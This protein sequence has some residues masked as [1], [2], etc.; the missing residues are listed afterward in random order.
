MLKCKIDGREYNFEEG[1]TILS[2]CI[3]VGIDIP[4]LC[5]LDG[6]SEEAACSLCVV[7]VKG[8]RTLIRACVTKVVEGME[9]FTDTERVK[10]ARRLNLELILANHPLDCMTC[11]K[12]GDC[13]LQDLAYEFDI[14]KSKFL[15]PDKIVPK[16]QKTPWDT[17]PFIEFDPDKCVLCGRCIN[18][19]SNQAVLETI[20]FAN[21]GHRQKVCPPFSMP[22]EDTDCKF[23][24]VCVQA[25]PV[26]ALIEKPRIGL[27]KLKDLIPTDTI[28]AYCGVGCN[29]SIYKDKHDKLIMAKGIENRKI[30]NGRLCVKGR[31]GHEYIDSADRLT[32]PLIKENG[33]FREATWAEA[34]RY[35]AKKL[36]EIKSKYSSDSIGVLGSSRCTNE[37]NYAIQKFARAVIGTNNVDNCARLCHSSTVAG[38]GMAFGAGAAT[39]SIQ[40]IEDSDLIFIIGSNMAET[41]PVIAQIVKGHMKKNSP[42]LIVCDPRYVGMAKSADLYI[43]HYPGTDV[44]LLNAIMK[45]IIE[46]GNANEEFI[47]AHAEGFDEF[48]KI[49]EGYDVN[50]ASKITGVDQEKIRE[51]AGIIG[52]AKSMMIFFSMGITQHTTGVDNVLSVANLALLTGN[53]GRRGAGVMPLRGQ[54]NVQGACDLGALPN[55]YPGYQKVTDPAVKEKFQKAWGVEL[56]DKI[57]LPVSEFAEESL[58]GSMKAV[59]IM[60]ENPLMT[61]ADLNRAKE[62]FEKLEFLAIQSIFLSETARIAD[63]VFPAAAAYEKDGT[64]TNTDRTVQLLRPVKKKPEGS[65]EDWE[66]VCEV[67]QAMGYR[68]S[69]KGTREIT[70]EIASLTPSYGG[71]HYERVMKEGIQWPC[72]D[73]KH[74]GT[75]FLHKDAVFKRPNGKGKF[76]GVEFK[77]AKELPDDEYPFILST[78]RMLYHYHSG[79]ETRR[80][81]PLNKFVPRNY[82]E[83]NPED[84]KTLK[85]KNDD[86][87]SVSTRRGSINVNAWISER[88]KKGVIFIP[89]HF[90]EAAANVLTNSALDPV[91]KIPE[92]KACAAKIEIFNEK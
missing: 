29:M 7:E 11:D 37:D 33:K 51:A 26:A 28:C 64:F 53:I 13:Q 18:A 63:V 67:A 68:M 14:K 40:D 78:G 41:H 25:C 9:V 36:G 24:A 91:S 49:V 70:E 79:N 46:N 3:S 50:E 2:A 82:V 83:I 17:N 12:D 22:L 80:V 76:S 39:N 60:G 88:P 16:K 6:V 58:K 5:Y 52:S 71:I 31:Y 84:A 21:R 38:L 35:T 42:T 27:G 87:V 65:K 43:Q 62:G 57:G 77:S 61:E 23:C 56:S 75:L 73:D 72:L 44:S 89:F 4:A 15:D 85:I 32:S 90:K 10:K 48:K 66:I 54:A 86:V 34:I 20:G 45:L 81:R 47:K 19:C 1:A 55:V 59:Y 69:Y 74:P 92:F 30:N 8:A